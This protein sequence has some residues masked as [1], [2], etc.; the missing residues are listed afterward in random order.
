MLRSV[1]QCGLKNVLLLL[2]VLLFRPGYEAMK[3]DLAV[4]FQEK[5]RVMGE[6]LGIL[7]YQYL[8]QGLLRK[9]REE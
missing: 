6:T 5:F 1:D 4:Y 9:M 7:G 8:Q 3:E 2:L